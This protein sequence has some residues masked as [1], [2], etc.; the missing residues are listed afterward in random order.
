[1]QKNY[2]MRAVILLLLCLVS[3][4]SVSQ[5][6]QKNQEE[7]LPIIL[8]D[9]EAFMSTQTGEYVYRSHADT[10]SEQLKT[11]PSGVVYTDIFTHNVK[12]KETLFSIAKKYSISVDEIKN[13]N[14]LSKANLKIGQKLKIIQKSIVKSSSPVVSYSGE[15]RI[16]ARLQPNQNPWELN[17]PPPGTQ[18]AN[19]ANSKVTQGI[20]QTHTVKSGETLFSIAKQYNKSV[21]ELKSLNNLTLNNLTIGQ[22]LKVQ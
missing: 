18:P 11:T 20:K 19:S 4:A 10:D 1:M 2:N 3:I 15:E 8:E 6:D 5:V 16:V 7:F 12:K 13:W 17:S 21:E 9:K 22:K 14:K